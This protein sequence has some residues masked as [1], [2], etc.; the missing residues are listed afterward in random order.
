M[1]R[2]SATVLVARS[3]WTAS[4]TLK[5]M[6]ETVAKTR[7]TGVPLATRVPAGML[8]ETATGRLNRTIGTVWVRKSSTRAGSM[9]GAGTS[10]PARSMRGGGGGAAPRPSAGR[11]A[12]S[13]DRRAH[14]RAGGSGLGDAGVRERLGAERRVGLHESRHGSS[15]SVPILVDRYLLFLHETH[16]AERQPDRLE[17]LLRFLLGERGER[18]HLDRRL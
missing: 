5:G 11:G 17:R 3:A 1:G 15:S 2:T 6:F 7:S 9:A 8:W 13:H 16:L 12:R 4:K 10:L 18:R 14:R